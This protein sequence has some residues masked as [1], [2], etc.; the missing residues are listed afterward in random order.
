MLII[1]CVI[2]DMLIFCVLITDMLIL[3][4]C[5]VNYRP[6]KNCSPILVT[7]NQASMKNA[8]FRLFS[9]NLRFTGVPKGIKKYNRIKLKG[10]IFFYGPQN[11]RYDQ[12]PPPHI[13]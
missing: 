5:T 7:Q 12:R 2:T 3:F 11:D 13:A 9:E 10:M 1:F 6:V 8:R 4:W